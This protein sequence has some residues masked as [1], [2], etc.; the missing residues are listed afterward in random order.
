MAPHPTPRAMKAAPALARASGR[1]RALARSV[2]FC[3]NIRRGGIILA[4]SPAAALRPRKREAFNRATR[5]ASLMAQIPIPWPPLPRPRPRTAPGRGPQ[6]VQLP[7]RGLGYYVYST[8]DRQYGTVEAV[9]T[10]LALARLWV[11]FP[12][13]DGPSFPFGIGD[14]SFADG[15]PMNPHTSHRDGRSA[16]IRPVRKDRLPHAVTIFDPQYDREETE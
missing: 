14:M 15:R 8:S 11:M 16:D 7:T 5:R 4:S 9:Q 13:G 2:R 10:L 12:I 6:Y 1:S 3:R